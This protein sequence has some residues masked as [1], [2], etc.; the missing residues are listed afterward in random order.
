[1]HI[2]YGCFLLG[3]GAAAPIGPVNLEIIRRNLQHGFATGFSFAR[4]TQISCSE[5]YYS[6]FF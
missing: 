1:M 4:K 6:F 3:L 2:F 5:F